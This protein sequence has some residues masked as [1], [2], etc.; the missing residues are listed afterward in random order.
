MIENLLGFASAVLLF[1]FL[2][3]MIFKR[4]W[5]WIKFELHSIR[6]SIR[7]M[8]YSR[9]VKKYYKKHGIPIEPFRPH[10]YMRGKE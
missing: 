9:C 2:W 7:W 8:W 3:H 10:R 4:M 6:L 5:K 1:T